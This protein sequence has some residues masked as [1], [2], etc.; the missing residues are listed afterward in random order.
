MVLFILFLSIILL[1]LLYHFFDKPSFPKEISTS[2]ALSLNNELFQKIDKFIE[3]SDGNHPDVFIVGKHYWNMLPDWIKWD[4]VKKPNKKGLQPERKNEI[5]YRG[6]K[7]IYDKE[8][9]Y[10]F[11]VTNK[12]KI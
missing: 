4:W 5:G 7:I 9:E 3:D 8:D 10:R 11:D 1:F 6:T 12:E 2:K